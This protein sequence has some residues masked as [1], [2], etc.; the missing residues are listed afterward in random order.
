MNGSQAMTRPD[1]RPV[2]ALALLALMGV[3]AF[4]PGF[5]V[6]PLPWLVPFACYAALVAVVPPL[7]ATFR[8]W[9]FGRVSAASVAATAVIGVGSCAILVAFHLLAH[10]NISDYGRFLPVSAFGS[11]VA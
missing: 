2:H 5:R 6:W 11:V 8:P 4:V 1:W 7:R 10:P 3:T 9:R